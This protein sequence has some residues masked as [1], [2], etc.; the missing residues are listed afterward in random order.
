ME[1]KQISDAINIEKSNLSLSDILKIT[2]DKN[3][4]QQYYDK[5]KDKLYGLILLT[6]TH[7]SFEEDKA[8]I[9]FEEILQHKKEVEKLLQRDIGMSVATLDYLQNIKKIIYNPIII[10]ENTSNF[11]TDSTTKD[12]LTNLYVRDILDVFLKKEIDN[13]KRK[14]SYVSFAMI[15]IDDFKAVNDTYGHQKGDEVL[16]TIGKIIN[17]NT[18][19]MD[20]AARYGGEELCIVMP[21]TNLDEAFKL[22]DRIRE[23]IASLSFK[24]FFVT[25]SIGISQSDKNTKDEIELIALADKALYKA[26]KNGKNQV[27]L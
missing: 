2:Q 26:K 10:E 9:I 24:D 1:E 18:R 17:H 20:F 3:R 23:E 19:E 21:N 15:D 13:A 11:L 6:L 5:Y 8:K 16:E 7:K 12:G 14:N 22:T 27:S 4:F 25:V